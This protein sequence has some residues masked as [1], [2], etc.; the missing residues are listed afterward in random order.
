[1]DVEQPQLIFGQQ[2]INTHENARIWDILGADKAE[3]DED[4]M[5]GDANEDSEDKKGMIGYDINGSNLPSVE[6]YERW[7]GHEAG[8]EL[9]AS[10]QSR[11]TN[12]DNDKF[13]WDDSHGATLIAIREEDQEIAPLHEN[14]IEEHIIGVIM[15]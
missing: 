7:G 5:I 2:P 15:M 11:H 1:M 4:G 13:H 3:E 10:R 6:K 14:E 8:M 9:M 12:K